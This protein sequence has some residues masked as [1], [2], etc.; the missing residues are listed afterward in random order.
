M[1]LYV[2]IPGVQNASK[3]QVSV[4]FQT[5]ALALSVKNVDGKNHELQIT[6]L[7]GQID[8]ESSLYKVSAFQ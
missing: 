7:L 6:G 1:K 5:K 4:N 3:E 2:T 8:P